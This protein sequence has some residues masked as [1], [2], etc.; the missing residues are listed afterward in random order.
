VSM[1]KIAKHVIDADAVKLVGDWIT[2]R[3]NCN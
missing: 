2:A 3:Q 1:P